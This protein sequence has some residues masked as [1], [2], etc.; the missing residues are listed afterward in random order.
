MIKTILSVCFLFISAHGFTQSF[1]IV[2]LDSAK[3]RIEQ[4]NLDQKGGVASVMYSDIADSASTVQKFSVMVEQK[5]RAIDDRIL[6]K[7]YEAMNA[8]LFRASGKRYEDML[9]DVIQ[10]HLVGN[11]ELVSGTDTLALVITKDMRIQ[12]GQIRGEVKYSSPEKIEIIGVLPKPQTVS[13]I[14]PTQLK[15]PDAVM[16]KV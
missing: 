10:S 16:R 15:G 5:K 2:R 13:F 7:Q 4:R 6:E 12:G 3:W 1:H 14:S 11:W 9:R 8:E